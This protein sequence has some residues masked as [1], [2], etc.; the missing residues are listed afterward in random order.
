M[1]IALDDAWAHHAAAHVMETEG[2]AA[3]G[4]KWLAHCAHIWESKGTFIREHNWWHMALF[5]LALGDHAKVLEIFDTKLWGE[6]PEFPQEQIGAASM[7][8]R[9]ELKGLDAGN[10]WQPVIEQALTRSD[11][12]IF[13]FHDLHYLFALTHA[14]EGHHAESHYAAMQKRAELC[15]AKTAPAWQKGGLPAAAG[16]LAYKRGKYDEAVR[17]FETAMPH[18]IHIGGSHAQRAIFNETYAQAKA[19]ANG[20]VLALGE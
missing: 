9:L 3:D 16:I 2:R 20:K 1:E 4:A 12:H 18:I 6:W 7:L 10:R 17:H 14:K 8:W 11:D 19:R 15:C 13:P 5:H